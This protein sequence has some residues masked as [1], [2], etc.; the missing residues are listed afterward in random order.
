MRLLVWRHLYFHFLSHTLL[1]LDHQDADQEI[2]TK[3]TEYIEPGRKKG[4]GKSEDAA[5]EL[6]Q[7]YNRAGT[8][9]ELD[10]VTRPN[11]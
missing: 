5:I 10:H 8:S 9:E 1:L 7:L 3:A 6:E 4:N 2:D 11:S